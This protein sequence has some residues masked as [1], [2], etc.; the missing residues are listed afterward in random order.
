MATRGSMTHFSELFS[1]LDN[2][3]GTGSNNDFIDTLKSDQHLYAIARACFVTKSEQRPSFAL[4]FAQELSGHGFW[5]APTRERLDLAQLERMAALS[6]HE[7]SKEKKKRER[8]C[9]HSFI[10][11]EWGQTVHMRD[12]QLSHNRKLCA[13]GQTISLRGITWR[14]GWNSRAPAL[15]CQ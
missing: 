3:H 6:I 14:W 7:L 15:S 5:M 9:S 8:Q 2:L 13:K 11:F 4:V 1:H 10:Q 12:E